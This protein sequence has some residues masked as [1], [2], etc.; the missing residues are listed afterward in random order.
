MSAPLEPS[1]LSL[2]ET[3]LAPL[4]S[5]V[6]EAV[7]RFS[8]SY[9]GDPVDRQPVHTVYGG[10][11]LFS[12]DTFGKLSRL[13]KKVFIDHVPDAESLSTVLQTS[14]NPAFSEKLYQRVCAKLDSQAIEDYRIDFEDGY[15]FRP[16]AEEDQHAQHCGREMAAA[17]AASSLPPFCG[18]RIKSL[19]PEL[20]DRSLRT[21]DLF[22]TTLVRETQGK[23]PARLLITLPKVTFVEQVTALAAALSGL[24]KKLRLPA[25]SILLELMIETPQSLIDQEGKSPLA[26]WVDAADGRCFAAHFGAY[27]FTGSLNISSAHQTLGHVACNFARQSMQTAL[28][29]RGV[30]WVDGATQ[31]MPIGDADTIRRAWRMSYANVRRGLEQGFYQ[32]WDLHP[33]QIPIRYVATYAFFHET[34]AISAERLRTFIDK[35]AQASLVGNYF[36]DAASGQGLLNFF[37]RG[38]SCGALTEE[39]VRSSGLSAEEIRG[40]SFMKIVESRR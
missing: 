20:M 19:S 2:G 23:I 39:E 34:M 33:A 10:A 15:G 25:K 40:R 37:L 24:E 38:M 21:L 11:Q 35:A 5:S 22:V 29:G 8:A 7:S 13:A 31:I 26:A 9:P 30:H 32:G 18:I 3:E 16:S 4:R 12:R 27:D 17:L 1:S 14:W 36:D 6:S 28:A